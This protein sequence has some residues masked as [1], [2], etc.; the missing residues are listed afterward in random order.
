M[1]LR[2][3]F[4]F[5]SCELRQRAREAHISTNFTSFLDDLFWQRLTGFHWWEH[6]VFDIELSRY[7]NWHNDVND[8]DDGP[9]GFRKV[10]DLWHRPHSQSWDVAY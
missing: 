9:V 7:A 1:L 10:L 4:F 3:F 6:P 5:I 8:Y 2:Q